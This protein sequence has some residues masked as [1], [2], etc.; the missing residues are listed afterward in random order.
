MGLV[1]SSTISLGYGRLSLAFK[2]IIEMVKMD[3]SPREEEEESSISTDVRYLQVIS[4]LTNGRQIQIQLPHWPRSFRSV[5]PPISS[6]ATSA[7]MRDLIYEHL[8]AR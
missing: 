4:V 2:T 6:P 3:D 7:L 1:S 8:V 5:S